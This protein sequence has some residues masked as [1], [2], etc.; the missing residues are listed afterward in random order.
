[1]KWQERAGPMAREHAG[2]LHRV[3]ALMQPGAKREEP[4]SPAA[5]E[6]QDEGIDALHARVERLEE[7]VE[8]LQDALYRHARHQDERIEELQRSMEPEELARAL[9]A[10]ARRRG[11]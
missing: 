5:A 2:L 1:M 3:G 11:L 10:D 6:P 9:S 7:V 8:G 4:E